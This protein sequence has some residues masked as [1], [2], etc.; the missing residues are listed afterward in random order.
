ML[1]LNS[2]PASGDNSVVITIERSR[3]APVQPHVDALLSGDVTAEQFVSAYR[4]QLEELRRREPD[5]FL[6]LLAQA[7]LGDVT[8][9]DQWAD[10]PHSPKRVLA[11]LL[12]EIAAEEK[13]RR[14]LHANAS[15]AAPPPTAP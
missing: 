9:A 8:L 2:A 11:G 7:R 14:A 3:F 13:R 6:D 15:D 4:L 10:E 5:R 12:R 1:Y